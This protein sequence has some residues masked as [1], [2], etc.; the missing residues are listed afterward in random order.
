MVRKAVVVGISFVWLA[1]TGCAV[2]GELLDPTGR[3]KSLEQSQK[4]Y[5]EL[6]RWGE[7]ERASEYVDPEM[8]IEYLNHA[9]AFAGIRFT[10][11]ESG[12]LLMDEAKQ[13]ATAIVVYHA[14][15]LS[16]LLEKQIRE[17]QEW[18]RDEETLIGWRVR[19]Q[20]R[21]VISGITGH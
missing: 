3:Q 4:R 19:P 12:Q 8:Q 14:Y 2:L 17:N 1:S 7:L 13:T 18:Y 16:T 9:E 15:S 6:V 5:T 21:Q 20:L 10:D 11:F